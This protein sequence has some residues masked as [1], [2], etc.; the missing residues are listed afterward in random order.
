V[1]TWAD[2]ALTPLLVAVLA[3]LARIDLRERRLPDRLTLPLLLAGLAL[4]AWRVGGVPLDALI[5]AA[6]GFLVFWAVGDA[7]F[8]LRGVE[9]LGLGDAKLLAAAGAWLGW[10]PLPLLV[11]LAALLALLWALAAQRRGPLAFGPW[12]AGAFFLLWLRH[13]AGA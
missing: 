1:A 6:A 12:L 5:G 11:L 10:R 2:L 8:R 9:G 4:A 7:H 3:L 13:L